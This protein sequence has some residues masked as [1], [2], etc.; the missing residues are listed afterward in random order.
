MSEAT[1]PADR[2]NGLNSIMRN[3]AWLIGGKGFGAICS[4]VYLALLS[5]SLGLKD[6]GH[7]SLIFGT[8]QALVALT[9]FQTWQTI[10]RYGAAPVHDRQWDQ[11]GRLVWFCAS[12]DLLGV[13][14]G[15]LVAVVVFFGFGDALSLNPEYTVMA[16]WFVCALLISR[17]TTP[18]GV[19]RGLDRFDIGSYV[20][21]IVPAGRLIAAGAIV[22]TGPSVARFLLA[23]AFFDLVSGF[24]YWVAARK[25]A[26]QALRF[27]NFGRWSE[28]LVENPGI[29]SFF[30]MTFAS[31]ALDA[32]FKQGPLLAVGYFLGTSA[33]G[34]YRLADQLA[35][36][37]SRFAQ[38]IARAVLPEFARATARDDR[39]DFGK[40]VQQV[41]IMAASG[42]AIVTLLAVVAG[43]WLLVLVGGEQ[44]AKGAPILLPLVI[45]SSFELAAVSFEPLLL[46]TGHA[47]K[48]V[49]AR[50]VSIGALAAA[51][52]LFVS[53]GVMIASWAVPIG[54]ALSSAGMAIAVNRVLRT[55]RDEP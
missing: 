14:L 4:L 28:A 33:A 6:F 47:I 55:M 12:I 41:S 30:A 45:A 21:A 44:F 15:C 18:T 10:V 22:L 31:A 46:S 7:F 23:W 2:R 53:E 13:A 52:L 17:M 42:G 8:A 26:P 48:A 51:F 1:R 24:L 29:R 54:M 35:Q 39:G 32:L 5:R 37:I 36:G 3:V 25:V 20:E 11:F 40:L 49:A 43:Q 27:G 19:V 34:L 50:A 9:S 16:F 38:L